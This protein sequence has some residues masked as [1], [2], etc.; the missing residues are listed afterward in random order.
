MTGLDYSLCAKDDSLKRYIRVE[1]RR[2]YC[3]NGEHVV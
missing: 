1:C 2:A 3:W